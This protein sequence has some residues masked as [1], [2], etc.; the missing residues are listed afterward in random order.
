MNSFRT[1]SALELAQGLEEARSYTLA[2]FDSFAAAGYG[3]PGKAPR[4]E[5]L[6]PPLWEL[7]HIAWFAEWFILREACSSERAAA[8]LPSLLSQGDKWFDP[9]AVPQGAR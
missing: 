2:L 7:G 8:S 9:E 3:E 6:D 1:A 5:H 4:H